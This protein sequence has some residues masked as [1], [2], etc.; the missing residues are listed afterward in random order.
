MKNWTTGIR[1]IGGLWI[2]LIAAGGLA[3][4]SAA[5][6]A[7]QVQSLVPWKQNAA[8]MGWSASLNRVIYNSRGADGMFDAYSANPDGSGAQCLTCSIPRFPIV[9]A[10]TQRGVSDVSSD[11]NDMLLEVE[12]GDHV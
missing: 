3:A 11:G 10:A 2:A 7:Y 6:S 5:A 9:G 4:S 1:R 12:R 8:P